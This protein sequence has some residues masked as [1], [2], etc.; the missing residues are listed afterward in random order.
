MVQSAAAK[1]ISQKK[2]MREILDKFPIKNCN[3]VSKSNEVVL[4]L[5]LGPK[6][7]KIGSRLYKKS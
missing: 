4:N 6:R 2:Y 3:Y 1:F 5:L 7:K